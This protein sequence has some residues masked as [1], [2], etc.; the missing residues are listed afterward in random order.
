MKKKYKILISIIIAEFIFLELLSFYNAPVNVFPLNMFIILVCFIP[1][2]ILLFF[3]GREENFSRRKR[4]VFKILFWH[5]TVCIVAATTGITLV[6][7]GV[8]SI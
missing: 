5:F 4:L 3:L 1:F 2:G 8:I 7:T 6:E